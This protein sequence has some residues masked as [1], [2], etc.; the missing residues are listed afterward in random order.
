MKKFVFASLLAIASTTVCAAP[1][2]MAQDQPGQVT[3]KDPAEYNAYSNATGQAD[4]KTKAAAIESFLS[5]YPQ[6]IVKADMLEQL[7]AAYQASGDMNKTVDAAGRLL[8]VDPTNLRALTVT[9]YIKKSQAGQLMA[10]DPAKAQALLDEAAALAQKGLN[11]T[12]PANM[13]AADYEKLKKA[14]TPIFDSA[15]AADDSGKKDYK[16]AIAAYRAELQSVSV[17]ET[18][19]LPVLNDTFLLGTAYIQMEPK[20]LLNG[21]WFLTR[22]AAYA[23]DPAK[24]QIDAQAKYWYNRYHGGMDG[25]ETVQALAKA[26]LFP[27]PDYKITPAPSPQE[28]VAKI[29]AETPDLKTLALSDKEFI[30]SNGKKE[31]AD[32]LWAQLQGV[33]TSVPGTVIAATASQVQLAVAEDA[34]ASKTADFTV[35]MKVPL[36]TVPAVGST[37]SLVATFD[38]YTQTPAMIVLKDGEVPAPAKKPAAHPAPR[39][40]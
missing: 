11:P 12:K 30:L 4:P 35:N 19:K 33:T 14:T 26:N 16:G 37:I 22:A 25:Y 31:D 34:K 17:E 5:T 21:I 15:I 23:P 38:S 24:A 8:Q 40:K 36:A 27:T 7:M 1:F 2:A 28:V 13:S 10:S 3:I 20:D 39:H 9:V 6:S 18:T 29:V 32:K